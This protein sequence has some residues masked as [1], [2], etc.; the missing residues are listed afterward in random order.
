MVG[1]FLS[2]DAQFEF[3]VWEEEIYST[4]QAHGSGIYDVE[5]IG[6]EY[7][8]FYFTV[9]RVEVSRNENISKHDFYLKYQLIRS[10]II[11][12]MQWQNCVI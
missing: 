2:Q 12:G 5:V 10:K 1:N 4:I 11:G 3:R 9:R 7:N 6:S 8:G